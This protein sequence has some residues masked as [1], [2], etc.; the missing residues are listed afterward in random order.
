MHVLRC[1]MVNGIFVPAALFVM[2]RSYILTVLAL[3]R[4]EAADRA[5]HTLRGLGEMNNN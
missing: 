3:R 2:V 5:R 1:I 4:G